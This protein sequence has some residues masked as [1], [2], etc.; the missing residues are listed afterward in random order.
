MRLINVLAA[1]LIGVTV[2]LVQPQ[3]TAALDGGEINNIAKQITVKIEGKNKGTGVIVKKEGNTYTVLTNHHV[4]REQGKYILI[5]PNGKTYNFNS[6]NIRQ[7]PNLDLAVVQFTSNDNYTVATLG[8]SNE[9][10]QS[11]EIYNFGWAVN[12]TICFKGCDRFYNGIINGIAPNPD[13]GYALIISNNTLPGMSGGPILNSQGTLVGINGLSVKNVLSGAVEFKGIPIN[14]YKPYQNLVIVSQ[15]TPTFKPQPPKSQPRTSPTATPQPTS[16]K[17]NSPTDFY[18]A[19]TFKGHSSY[20]YS[21]AISADGRTLASG[22]Y[23]KN[24][25]IWNLATGKLIRTLS[26]HSHA[27]LSVAISPDGRT[28][29]S[30]GGDKTIKIWR[31]SGR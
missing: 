7:L 14:K 29:A 8:D 1:T 23:D 30:G 31:V 12:D 27:V 17:N 10:K 13:E 11:T 9:L 19:N 18:L 4:V 15:P 25:K 26:G 22:S 6:S 5:T 16:N 3:N 24:I 21:V 20:V 2:I 28:L